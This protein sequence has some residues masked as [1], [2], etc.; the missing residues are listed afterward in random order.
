MSSSVRK[1]EFSPVLCLSFSMLLVFLNFLAG[2]LNLRIPFERKF[3]DEALDLVLFA[4]PVIVLF[5]MA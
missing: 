3:I 5:D 4:A 1:N 2:F